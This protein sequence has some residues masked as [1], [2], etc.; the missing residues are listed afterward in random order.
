MI[1]GT[2]PQLVFNL[3]FDVSSIKTVWVTFSQYNREVFTIETENLTMDG[4]TVS[5][6]L[7]QAQ[8]LELSQNDSVE[9]QLRILTN[10]GDALASNI[11]KASA[12]KILKDGE[13]A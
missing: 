10:N 9:I 6:E 11:M 8:T 3:P 12:G 2:T 7:T 13:I 5:V 1:R 4:M